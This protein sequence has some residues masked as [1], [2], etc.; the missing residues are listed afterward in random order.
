MDNLRDKV[1]PPDKKVLLALLISRMFHS[2]TQF[3]IF[4]LQTKN[5]ALAEHLALGEYYGGVADFI[6]KLV[7]TYQGQY[8]TVNNYANYSFENYTGKE[9]AIKILKD[10][11]AYID[12][13]KKNTFDEKDS[14][15]FN[16]LDE[17]KTHI[18]QVLFKLRNL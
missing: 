10:F 9:Q 1:G 13:S 15:F 2:E 12:N 7:E 4:H 11:V 5:K 17:F 3:H 6:D 14:D 16:I 8:D 18:K